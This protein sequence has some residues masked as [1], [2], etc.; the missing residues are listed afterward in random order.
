MSPEL[1]NTVLARLVGAVG[2]RRLRELV[3]W[4][5]APW[6]TVEALRAVGQCCPA[7]ERLELAGRFDLQELGA[8]GPRL[9]GYLRV[10]H[11]LGAQVT[12]Y[13]DSDEEQYVDILILLFPRSFPSLLVNQA[14]VSL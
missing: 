4:V 2:G 3:L 5:R 7:L 1:D 8:Q 6:L 12:E 9:F 11:L 10:L 14:V 13:A